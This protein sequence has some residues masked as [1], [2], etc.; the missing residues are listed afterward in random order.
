MKGG[1]KMKIGE[2]LR[3]EQSEVYKQINNKP[4]SNRRNNKKSKD[5]KGMTFSQVERLMKHDSYKRHNGSLRQRTWG[6]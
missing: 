6:Q 4:N 1:R 2:I 5:S 3:C